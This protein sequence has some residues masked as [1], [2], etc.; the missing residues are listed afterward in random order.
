MKT[1]ELMLGDWVLDTRTNLPLKVNPFMAELEV[2][3]WQPI[4]LTPE[5][6]KKNGFSYDGGYAVLELEYDCKLSHYFHEHRLTK[7]YRDEV[8]FRCQCTYVHEF[9]HALK[10]FGIDKAIVL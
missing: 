3:E 10:L 9:Q 2:P 4:P 5:I 6:L 7:F 1:N 8:L